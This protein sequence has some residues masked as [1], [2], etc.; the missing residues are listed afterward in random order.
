MDVLALFS[1]FSQ[2]LFCFNN[3]FTDTSNIM[4]NAEKIM[5]IEKFN[6]GPEAQVKFNII[7]LLQFLFVIRNYIKYL[8]KSRIDRSCKT[9]NLAEE[10]VLTFGG[11]NLAGGQW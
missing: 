5:K 10:H 9:E 3:N 6:F 1:F 8:L 4:H 11:Q 7:V 2:F